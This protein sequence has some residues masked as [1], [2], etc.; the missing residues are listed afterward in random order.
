MTVTMLCG[1][2][3]GCNSHVGYG[4]PIEAH[5][6]LFLVDEYCCGAGAKLPNVALLLCEFCTEAAQ[7]LRDA[8]LPLNYV[9]FADAVGVEDA[10]Q[11]AAL[12]DGKP[13]DPEPR[14]FVSVYRDL[15]A[16]GPRAGREA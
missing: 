9:V 13:G 7:A 12:E 14:E 3:L 10:E 11:I 4:L 1:R 6:D 15:L 16:A 2:C 8:G 5:V